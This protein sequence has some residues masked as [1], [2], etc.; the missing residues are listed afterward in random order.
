MKSDSTSHDGAPTY[1]NPR[2]SKTVT[3]EDALHAE[4]L[5]DNAMLMA[6]LVDW[7]FTRK[8]TNPDRNPS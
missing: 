7:I 1:I 4:R 3:K 8:W 6:Q 2:T 5:L